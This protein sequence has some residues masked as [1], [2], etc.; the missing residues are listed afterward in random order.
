MHA[1]DNAGVDATGMLNMCPRCVL[2]G[3]PC[4]HSTLTGV[5]SNSFVG[6]TSFVSMQGCGRPQ[7]ADGRK[8]D[9]HVFRC[10]AK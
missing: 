10:V 1:K 6:I 5:I 8:V 7:P 4:L 2:E 3:Y 9:T